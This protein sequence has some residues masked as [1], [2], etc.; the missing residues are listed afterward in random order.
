MTTHLNRRG[1]GHLCATVLT[2]LTLTSCGSEGTGGGRGASPA[3]PSPTSDPLP[4]AW[5]G[6]A[7]GVELSSDA[8]AVR[9][10]LGA[11][12]TTPFKWR[13]TAQ[14]EG[15]LAEVDSGYTPEPN[16]EG[17]SGLGGGTAWW[18]LE[19]VADGETT[20]TFTYAHLGGE[21]TREPADS[22]VY[23]LTVEDGVIARMSQ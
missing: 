9:L 21:G 22:R 7:P 18:V 15:V 14:P 11:N 6:A 13:Y 1:L 10:S 23:R 19:A 16:P 4:T 8:T 3:S 20:L 17:M 12:N 2:A 5:V